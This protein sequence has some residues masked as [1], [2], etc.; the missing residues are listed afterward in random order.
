MDDTLT[1][2]DLARE[3]GVDQRTIRNWLR[4]E[5]GTLPPTEK[6]WRLTE[7]QGAHLRTRAI[8]V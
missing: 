3:L 6:R 7:A 8:D 2:A 5:Y 1:P 4:E